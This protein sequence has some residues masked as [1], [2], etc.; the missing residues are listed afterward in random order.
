MY[1]LYKLAKLSVI[2]ML[3]ASAT[4]YVEENA[5]NPLASVNNVDARWQYT[6][7]D[8]GDRHDL[9]ID[10]ARLC[11]AVEAARRPIPGSSRIRTQIG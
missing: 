1:K 4:S 8:A 7:A 2:L 3:V 11:K 5:S 9:F 6:P 10:D